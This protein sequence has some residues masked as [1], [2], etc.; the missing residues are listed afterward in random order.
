MSKIRDL[1]AQKLRRARL[2][3]GYSNKK[4]KKRTGG[5]GVSSRLGMIVA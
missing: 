5:M 4:I 2:F 3:H 1:G